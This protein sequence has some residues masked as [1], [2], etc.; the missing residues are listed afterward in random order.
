MK[1]IQSE[2]CE[3]SGV[4]SQDLLRLVTFWFSLQSSTYNWSLVFSLDQQYPVDESCSKN[5]VGI[6]RHPKTRDT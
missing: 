6:V 1:R 2:V 4:S 3:A 5:Y